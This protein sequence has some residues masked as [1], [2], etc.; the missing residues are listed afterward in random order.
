MEDGLGSVSRIL[1]DGEVAED[2]AG[3]RQ[4][5]ELDRREAHGSAQGAGDELRDADLVAGN[6]DEGR[7]DREGDEDGDSGEG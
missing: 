3:A 4:D 2:K 7:K 1:G 6:A 5:A